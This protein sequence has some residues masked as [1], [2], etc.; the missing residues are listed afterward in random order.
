LY[1]WLDLTGSTIYDTVAAA[2]PIIDLSIRCG[3]NGCEDLDEIASIIQ[4]AS[5]YD[6]L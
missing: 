5:N 3:P 6:R 4:R 2:F 1:F